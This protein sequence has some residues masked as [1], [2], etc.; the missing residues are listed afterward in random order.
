MILEYNL[1][2]VLRFSCNNDTV[3]TIGKS[4]LMGFVMVEYAIYLHGH[5]MKCSIA[6]AN[7]MI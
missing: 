6:N 4:A 2:N 3:I 7:Y 5:G 1:Y